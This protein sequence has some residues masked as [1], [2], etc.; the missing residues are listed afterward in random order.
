[1]ALIKYYKVC[2]CCSVAKSCPAICHPMDWNMP[3]FPA[4]YHLPEFPQ[5]HAH[6]VSD[7]IQPSFPLLSPFFCCPQ[8]FPALGS[9]PMSRFFA[10]GG[11]SIGAPA[12]ASVLPMKIQGWLPLGLTSLLSLLSKGLSRVFSN[13]RVQNI[14]SLVLNV[15]H[16]ST[17]TS[18]YVY[19]KNHSF[20]YMDICQQSDISPF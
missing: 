8:S 10:S 11:Q 15:F 6:W 20:D 16:D 7:G 9:F 17:L 1:M 12:S 5:I 18:I 4:L 3:G 14:N 2:C 19:W 13:T